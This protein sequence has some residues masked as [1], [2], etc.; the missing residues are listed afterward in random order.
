MNHTI[1]LLM[2]VYNEGKYIKSTIESALSQTYQNWILFIS[3]NHST[4]ETS[5]IIDDLAG[6]DKRIRKLRP[7]S[8]CK[9]SLDHALFLREEV[10]N[11]ATNLFGVI[12][13]GGH[14]LI[15]PNYLELLLNAMLQDTAR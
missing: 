5:T 1:G 2:A 15:S 9:A 10:L 6:R 12:S 4:D 13:I 8:H 7:P 14:D 11:E 3:D